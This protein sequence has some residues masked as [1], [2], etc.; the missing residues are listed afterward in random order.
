MKCEYDNIGISA[1]VNCPFAD[2]IRDD[3][4]CD[5]FS[6]SDEPEHKTSEAYIGY[7]AKGTKR[8]Y[9]IFKGTY[10][11]DSKHRSARAYA[12]RKRKGIAY[13]CKY[14]GRER[15]YQREY[16]EKMPEEQRERYRAWQREYA[17]RKRA[18]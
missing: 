2:C 9:G 6:P 11:D 15:E 10:L 4:E 1:C 7:T 12:E 16:R 13:Q 5:P 8:K 17:R 14:T 18:G 3:I